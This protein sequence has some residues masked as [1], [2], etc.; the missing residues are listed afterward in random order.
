MAI[1]PQMWVL[2]LQEFFSHRSSTSTL[3]QLMQDVLN[4]IKE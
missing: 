4:L 1:K 2:Q 3:D